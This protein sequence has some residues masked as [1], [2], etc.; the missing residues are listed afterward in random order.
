MD[1]SESRQKL[2]EKI[3]KSDI[4]SIPIEVEGT[5]IVLQR[6]GKYERSKDSPN[7]GGLTG[8]GAEEVRE[9][10]REFFESL[11]ETIPEAER[12]QVDVL[13]I[14]SDTQYGGG[15]RRCIETAERV[16]ESLREQLRKLG[17]SEEQLLN[18]SGRFTGGSDVRP[19]PKLREPQMFQNSPEFVQFLEEKYGGMG[20]NFWIAFEEDTEKEAREAM[21]AEGPDEIADRLKFEIGVVARYAKMYHEQH[22]GRRLVIWMVTHYDT[23]SP[24]V[25]RDI[26]EVGKEVPLAVDYG[27]GISI[28]LGPTGE[29][30]TEIAG[31]QYNVPL[32][33]TH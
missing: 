25:K 33:T 32:R 27:A 4:E 24:Y 7:V 3:E 28:S 10:G 1:K 23:I 9:V 20:R 6:H 11:F 17:L 31:E 19:T 30:I 13:I 12:G 26:F 16:T 15:G 18:T 29:A 14:A 8:E 22:P 21:G 5:E 2:P